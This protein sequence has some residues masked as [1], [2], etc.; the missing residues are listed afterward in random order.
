M[1]FFCIPHIIIFFVV[2]ELYLNVEILFSLCWCVSY[3]ELRVRVRSQINKLGSGA[4]AGAE[5]N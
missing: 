4:G 2:G 1:C 3:P 5:S